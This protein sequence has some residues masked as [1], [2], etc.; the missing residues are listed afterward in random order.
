[1]R[2]HHLNCGT[3][4]PLAGSVIGASKVVDHC[5][6]VES[7]SGLVLVDTGFGTGDVAAPRRI[8]FAFQHIVRPRLLEEETAIAQVRALGFDPADVRDIVITHLDADH[9]GGLG[10]FPD[11]NIHVFTRERI[12]AENPNLRERGRYCH[13]QIDHGPKWVDHEPDGDTWFGFE[14]VRVLPGADDEVAL[15]P[16]VGHSR[17][18]SGVAVRG[19]DGWILHCGDAIFNASEIATPPS[20]PIGLKIYQ[21]TLAVDNSSRARNVERLQELAREHGDEVKVICSHDPALLDEMTA[22]G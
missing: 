21:R 1:M 11:A 12:A 13:A 14:S 7:P 4:C 6:L 18:H 19:D 5:L 3:M 16:L 20:G 22:A 17:G 8:P 10:D 2:V 15:I 9:A